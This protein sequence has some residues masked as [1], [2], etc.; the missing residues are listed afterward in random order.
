MRHTIFL[1]PFTEKHVERT[2]QWVSKPELQHVF[3]IRG[4]VTWEGH[5]NYF[6]KVLSDPSQ[7]VYAI[8]ADG[9]HVGNCGFK[10][11]SFSKAEAEIWIYIGEPSERSK[12]IG[13][14]ATELLMKD[15]LE[16]LGLRSLYLHVADFNLAARKMYKKLGFIEVPLSEEAKEWQNRGCRV[17]RMEL[18][19][20]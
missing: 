19:K 17:I 6:G 2:F 3:L 16:T 15:G 13:R 7:K 20:T 10:N 18:K 1:I 4:N 11:M 12:G 5:R 9:R 8:F 14:L